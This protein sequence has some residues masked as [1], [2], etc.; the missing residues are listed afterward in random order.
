MMFLPALCVDPLN[1]AGRPTPANLALYGFRGV[2]H[3][4]QD[5]S[6]W[7]SYHQAVK[8]AGLTSIV[9]L[10]RESFALSRADTIARL[11]VDCDWVVIG[12]EP[13]DPGESS[14][15]MPPAEFLALAAE[16]SALIRQRCPGAKI[17]GGGL[18][19]GQPGWLTPIVRDLKPLIDAQDVHPYAK[20]ASEAAA[21]LRAYSA[22]TGGIPLV[23]LEWNRPRDEIDGFL[24]MLA[25]TTEAGAFFCWSDGMVENFGLADRRGNPKQELGAM[26]A[27]LMALPPGQPMSPPGDEFVLGFK[28]FHDAEPALIGSPIRR[29]RGGVPGFSVQRSSRGRLMAQYLADPATNAIQGWKIT[30]WDD[31]TDARYLFDGRKA[32]KIA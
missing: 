6:E 31:A 15:H 29:E 25:Q 10:A 21:L 26:Q 17:V 28:A 12:N 30:F 3:V 1:P 19:S 11:P 4:F 2:R 13:D 7:H 16:C 8:R 9:T 24:K 23:V 5:R 18:S 32:V 14:W 20:T 27:A 22:I